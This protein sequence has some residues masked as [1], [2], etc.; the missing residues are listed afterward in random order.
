MLSFRLVMSLHRSSLLLA[1]AP[2]A[3]SFVGPS[4]AVNLRQTSSFAKPSSSFSCSRDPRLVSTSSRAKSSVCHI[5]MSSTATQVQADVDDI[6]GPNWVLDYESLESSLLQ[7]HISE[8]SEKING[9]EKAAVSIR[10]LV[11]VAQ[12]LS[13]EE[14]SEADLVPSLVSMH[15][16]FWKTVVILQ[17][18]G[19]YASCMSSVDGTNEGAKK[20]AS[21]VQVMFA[22]TRQAYEA[23]SL[24]LDLCPEEVF[25]TF[26]ETDDDTK[27]SEYVLR[28]SRKLRR[29]KLSLEEENMVTRLS[30]TGH[31]TW[32]SMYTDISSVIPVTLTLNGE[33]KTMGI[34]SAEAMRDS[35]DE[36]VRR[37]SWEGIREGWLPHQETCAAALNAI[38]GW[39]LDD[40]QQRGY[41]NFLTSS[42]HSN[43]MSNASLQALLGAIDSNVDVGRRALRIQARALGKSAVDPWDLY[44]P[45]PI[46]GNVGR[47]YTFDEGIELIADAVGEVDEK[48]GAFVRMMKENKWIE[49]SR[50]DKK[51]PGA[52]Q[53]SFAVS[54]TPRVYLSDYNGRAQL[55]L[56]LA[57]ELG[58]AF[59][60]WQMRDMPQ[61]Q[62]RYPM[63]LAE[64]ASIF[65]ETVVG[66]KL[67]E[68]AESAE[69]RLSILW[70]E[71]ESAATFLLNIPSRFRF[72][73]ELNRRRKDGKLSVTEIDDMMVDAWTRY[74]GDS[75]RDKKRVGVFS[76][77]KLHFYL[78]GISFYNWPYSFGYLFALGVY[79]EYENGNR[80]TFRDTYT[81]L[82]RDTGRMDAEDV[83][84]KH[85]GGRIEEKTF[86]E[87]AIRVAEG[88]VALLDEALKELGGK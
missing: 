2:L 22:K 39:R 47:I 63:N 73:E 60:T 71:G 53:T 80:E 82:L 32:S 86:W 68:K 28:H 76:Q 37:A 79:A 51:R 29:H 87:N 19:T 11:P 72:E 70:G 64:T 38:T 45:A 69:E 26:L 30:V 8:A 6:S 16:D 65:F 34:A 81:N 10:H 59:H 58:H 49:A 7:R 36:T 41:G 40:Y 83:V 14:A 27:S 18:V 46:T 78:T 43:R 84:R 61:A 35:P 12:T 85:L 23:A 88:K 20:L 52:Y 9:M 17:N 24:I 33:E 31:N 55:L 62:L 3:L 74:Y 1:T 5:K 56:T 13:S 66:N 67:L 54:R 4:T 48:A 15:Q 77:S 57:H 75:L 42:L 44:A 50:G 25:T 21:Q